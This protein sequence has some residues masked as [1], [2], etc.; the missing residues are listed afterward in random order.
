MWLEKLVANLND[1]STYKVKGYKYETDLAIAA[2][3]VGKAVVG[4]KV[5]KNELEDIAYGAVQK[6]PIKISDLMHFF[7]PS[8]ELGEEF[9]R[10]KNK[11][12]ISDLELDR[13]DLLSNLKNKALKKEP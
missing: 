11:W 2:L 8:K 10:L 3:T 7:P 1:P 4:S 5:E 12:F 6:F 13:D 9:K